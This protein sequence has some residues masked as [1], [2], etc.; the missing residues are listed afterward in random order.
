ML[1][2]P[3]LSIHISNNNYKD[4]SVGYEE[5]KFIQGSSL[6]KDGEN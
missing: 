1:L 4:K 2:E 6:S 5:L 3:S